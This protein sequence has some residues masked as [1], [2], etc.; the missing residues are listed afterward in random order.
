[1]SI[2]IFVLVDSQLGTEIDNSQLF[3]VYI[4]TVEETPNLPALLSS[5]VF[6]KRYLFVN[7][8]L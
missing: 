6:S 4:E 5:T 3:A 8:Y 1:M 2:R 7:F